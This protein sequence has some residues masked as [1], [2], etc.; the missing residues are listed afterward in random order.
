[1]K[2]YQISED[3]KRIIVSFINSEQKITVLRYEINLNG[4]NLAVLLNKVLIEVINQERTSQKVLQKAISCELMISSHYTNE[5]WVCFTV[6]DKDYSIVASIFDPESDVSFLYYSKNLVQ[7]IGTSIIR[8]TI[9]PDK[10]KS[11]VCLVDQKSSLNCILYN[12]EKNEFS[13]L[14]KFAYGLTLYSYNMG[15][16]YL[17]EKKEYLVY[18]MTD[19]IYMHFIQ[20]DENFNLKNKDEDNDKCYKFFNIAEAPCFTILYSYILYIKIDENYSMLRL[21]AKDSENELN[22]LKISE[23]CNTKIEIDDFIFGMNSTETTLPLS[24]ENFISTIKTSIPIFLTTILESEKESNS[25]TSLPTLELI[26]TT[27][28]TSIISTSI[29]KSLTPSTIPI[30]TSTLLTSPLTTIPLFLSSSFPI[31]LDSAL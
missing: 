5:L 11:L 12:S 13:N 6:E 8:S 7:T 18:C 22:L 24:S 31:S 3:K 27:I 1:M 10:I 2:V 23:T 16:N 21:C 29:S 4:G 9:S 15:V 30:Y 25:F 19:S 17:A 14:I 20:F 28:R 26:T